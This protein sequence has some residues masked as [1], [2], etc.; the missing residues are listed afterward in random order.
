MGA[1][2]AF[3]IKELVVNC[4]V[5][6]CVAVCR[7]VLWMWVW[8][9]VCFERPGFARAEAGFANRKQCRRLLESSRRAAREQR[10]SSKRAARE[11]HSREQQHSKRINK[12]AA[13]TSEVGVDVG[14]GMSVCLSGLASPGWRLASPAGSTAG[15]CR[16]AAGEQQ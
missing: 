10:E 6:L 3:H 16:K 4:G 8:V 7:C 14:V 1:G 15:D 2:S 5:S 11:Q 13:T 12:T 9:W